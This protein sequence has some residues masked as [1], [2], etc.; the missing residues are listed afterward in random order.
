MQDERWGSSKFWLP[1]YGSLP[2]GPDYTGR[3]HLE[4]G[5]RHCFSDVVLGE[6]L[7]GPHVRGPR[8]RRLFGTLGSVREALGRS[9]GG[10]IMGLPCKGPLKAQYVS[11]TEIYRLVA[12]SGEVSPIRIPTISQLNAQLA[13]QDSM[14]AGV[15][16]QCKNH[17]NPSHS[18][19]FSSNTCKASC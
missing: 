11:Q 7:R 17:P 18:D 2:C 16:T 4:N 14:L 1:F 12:S 6:T 9:E 13:C 3:C 5:D 15:F 10:L 8:D 19:G